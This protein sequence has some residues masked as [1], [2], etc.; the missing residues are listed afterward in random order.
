[1][2]ISV[3]AMARIGWWSVAALAVLVVTNPSSAARAAAVSQP[4][5]ATYVSGSHAGEVVVSGTSTLHNWTVKSSA[6]QGR[7]VLALPAKAGGPG[8]HGSRQTTKAV[9]PSAAIRA[10]QLRIPVATLKSSEGSGMDNTVYHALKR[11]QDPVI[12]YRL[13][14]ATLGSVPSAQD[15]AYHFDTVGQLTVA[16]VTQQVTLELNV[17]PEPSNQLTVTTMVP[18]KMTQFGVKPPTAMF[19]LIRSGDAIAVKATWL[20]TEAK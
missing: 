19:G 11:R 13:I 14:R 20:L 9:A 5:A 7:L 8:T 15:P 2:R 1:M 17:W 12:S 16:G 4:A 10:I 3:T 18:L 6:I